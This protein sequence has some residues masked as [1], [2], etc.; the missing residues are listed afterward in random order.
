M[1]GLELAFFSED[2]SSVLKRFPECVARCIISYILNV[3]LL[4]YKSSII[5]NEM[6]SKMYSPLKTQFKEYVN[7]RYSRGEFSTYDISTSDCRVINDDNVFDVKHL[8]LWHL[9]VANHLYHFLLP[10]FQS[11]CQASVELRVAFVENLKLFESSEELQSLL[12]LCKYY[13]VVDDRRRLKF[14]TDPKFKFRF[15]YFGT[16]SAVAMRH[17]FDHID[18]LLV[19]RGYL[20]PLTNEHH[21]NTLWKRRILSRRYN[22]VLLNLTPYAHFANLDAAKELTTVASVPL[23]LLLEE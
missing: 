2:A 16:E 12:D 22:C 7:S 4:K 1:S 17:H 23:S 21:S 8:T 3:N 19:D 9:R 5:K 6:H 13:Y 14:L 11:I 10:R 18:G 15:G 20:I